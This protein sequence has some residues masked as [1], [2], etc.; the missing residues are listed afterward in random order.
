MKNFIVTF[1]KKVR[2]VIE[3]I[4]TDLKRIGSIMR[5][6]HLIILIT[7]VILSLVQEAHINIHLLPSL[8]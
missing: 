3:N 4:D 7:T 2:V 6:V 5:Q 1:Y 8:F